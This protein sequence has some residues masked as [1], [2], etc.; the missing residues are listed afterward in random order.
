[1]IGE[2]IISKANVDWTARPKLLVEFEYIG[3]DLETKGGGVVV[4]ESPGA[5]PIC[6]GLKGYVP[7]DAFRTVKQRTKR[8]MDTMIP[9]GLQ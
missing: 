4:M 6:G 5:E 2:V 8:L 3:R 9:K 7:E 1:M